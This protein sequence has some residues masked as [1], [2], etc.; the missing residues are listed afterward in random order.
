M[1]FHFNYGTPP[2]VVVRAR[3]LDSFEEQLAKA[4]RK[5]KNLNATSVVA[6]KY[7]QLA[8]NSCKVV[9]ETLQTEEGICLK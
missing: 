7:M 6:H 2:P 1:Q 4:V 8:N 3:N 9:A 5:Y